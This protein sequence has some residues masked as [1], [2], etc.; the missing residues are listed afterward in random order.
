M[1]G[2]NKT[3]SDQVSMALYPVN[4]KISDRLCVVVGGGKVAYRKVCNLLGC[5]AAVRIVSPQVDPELEKVIHHNNIEWLARGYA[6][7]DVRDAFLV[8]AAT[9]NRDVQH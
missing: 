2:E 3:C 6:Q 5:G 9:D 8:F 4:V 1:L 7:G